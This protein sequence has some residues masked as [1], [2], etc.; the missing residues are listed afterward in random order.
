MK[1]FANS[2]SFRRLLSIL[3]AALAGAALSAAP[4]VRADVGPSIQPVALAAPQTGHGTIKGDRCNVRSRPSMNAE[5][6]VQLHKGDT[7]EVLEHK[8]VA[9]RDK[10]MEWLR[11]ALP[12][13][14]KCFI[15]T[16]LLT[17]GI[18][19]AESVNVRCGPGTNY[20]DVG[21][22]PKGTRVEVVETTG[23]WARIKPT[24]ECSGWIAAEL[25]DV[26][27][28]APPVAMLPAERSLSTPEVIT[29]P[30]MP[31]PAAPEISIVNIDPD[32][33]VHYVAKDGYLHT[34]TDPEPPAMY[35]LRT[36]ESNR[37]SYRIAYLDTAE[38]DLRKFEGKHVRIV[39]NQRW[40]KGDRYAIIAVE[41][42]DRVW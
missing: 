41:R 38:T 9:E 7:V 42:I 11:V 28:V 40:R 21:K 1:K 31:G 2:C 6:V 8:A 13:T 33:Q 37:L 32:V 29:R 10:S 3:S 27:T 25:V 19:H 5:V 4:S 39:G 30:V 23:E 16:K 18:V 12:A 20:R 22:L 24:P 14:A 17:D 15:S 36:P 26:V 35:E 34:V